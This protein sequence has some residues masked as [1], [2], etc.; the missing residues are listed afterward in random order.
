LVTLS[1]QNCE[2]TIGRLRSQL[3]KRNENQQTIR[4]LLQPGYSKLSVAAGVHRKQLS[5]AQIAYKRAVEGKD[6]AK[7][8]GLAPKKQD[9]GKQRPSFQPYN[10]QSESLSNPRQENTQSDQAS[11]GATTTSVDPASRSYALAVPEKNIFSEPGKES[12]D[13]IKVPSRK[14]DRHATE[15]AQKPYAGQLKTARGR[16][17]DNSLLTD[18]RDESKLD[19]SASPVVRVKKLRYR[20]ALRAPELSAFT[21]ARY[22]SVSRV[23]YTGRIPHSRLGVTERGRGRNISKVSGTNV[24]FQS[25]YSG[26][27]MNIHRFKYAEKN[28]SK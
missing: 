21:S 24:S 1:P 20:S 3:A 16:P 4:A 9:S 28:T 27:R 25:S 23:S 6:P 5:E 8:Y 17:A 19:K 22:P 2:E 11:K 26:I 18:S 15:T 13:M 14:V 10:L 12:L 7:S